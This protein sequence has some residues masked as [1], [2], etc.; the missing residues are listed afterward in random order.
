[1]VQGGGKGSKSDSAP[2][3]TITI[4]R[5][6][7]HRRTTAT[8]GLQSY[9]SESKMIQVERDISRDD[10]LFIQIQDASVDAGIWLT[11]RIINDLVTGLNNRG[12]KK[13]TKK[14]MEALLASTQSALQK[15]RV[16]PFEAVGIITAQS[17]GEP[18]TQMTM[19]TFHY[20]GVATVNVTQ[21]LPRIIEIVDARKTPDTPTMNIFLD[22]VD[23]KGKPFNTDEK[24]VQ[25]LAASL[26][27]TLTPDIADIDVNVAQRFLTLV[28][29][30]Q[31][32]KRRA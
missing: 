22:S 14:Q 30:V 25:A 23:E 13:L 18:G 2:A 16:D 6:K 9:D 27:T 1:M 7:V 15:T 11:P 19:R 3:Q 12:V 5:K 26:E 21:G 17:I 28:F 31:I 32:S 20:A 10:P 29:V 8:R 4:K 24:K